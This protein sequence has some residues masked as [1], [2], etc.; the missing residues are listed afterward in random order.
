[1]S[2]TTVAPQGPA[3]KLLSRLAEISTSLDGTAAALRRLV[4][5]AAEQQPC[6]VCG[7]PPDMEA[8]SCDGCGVEMHHECFWGRVATLEEWRAWQQSTLDGAGQVIGDEPA[9]PVRCPSCRATGGRS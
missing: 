6:P 2:T 1:M 4:A 9:P 7:Y 5:G 3:P 8:W